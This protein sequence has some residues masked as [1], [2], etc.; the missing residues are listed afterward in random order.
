MAVRTPRSLGISAGKLWDFSG[1]R[2][3]RRLERRCGFAPVVLAASPEVVLR[4][5]RKLRRLEDAAG[6]RNV[7]VHLYEEIDLEIPHASIGPALNDFAE[8]V[9][10]LAPFAEDPSATEN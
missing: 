5:L 3:T 2:G 8:L 1:T 4:K 9:A 7:L 6:M 10:A